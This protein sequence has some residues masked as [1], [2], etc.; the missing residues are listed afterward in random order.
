MNRVRLAI[1]A[2]VVVL[3]L[4]AL[5]ASQSAG[6]QLSQST[7]SAFAAIEAAE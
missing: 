3:G 5:R 4:L 6:E 1:F 7:A 2:V